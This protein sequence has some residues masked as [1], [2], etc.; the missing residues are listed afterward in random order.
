MTTKRKS[1]NRLLIVLAV[2]TIVLIGGAVVAKQKGWIGKDNATQVA[3]EAVA[4]RDIIE[5]V[6]ASGK[7]YPVTEVAL[8]PDASGE[9][10]ELLVEEGDLIRK[11]QLLA[12]INPETYTSIVEQA[13]A[14]VRAAQSN[15]GSTATPHPPN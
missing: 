14:A 12:R 1:G 2:L 3:V 8:A 10:V 11:G 15:E 7:I 13:D 6:S 9:I 4:K 5:T